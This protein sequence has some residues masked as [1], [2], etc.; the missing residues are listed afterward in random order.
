MLSSVLKLFSTYKYL[1]FA[2]ICAGLA[3]GCGTVAKTLV[4]NNPK[5]EHILT[6]PKA[7]HTVTHEG[8]V[9]YIGEGDSRITVLY[10]SGTPYEMGYE[11]GRLLA[12][13]VKA[14]IADVQVGAYKFLP[15]QLRT[16]KMISTRDEDVI[17]DEFLDRAWEMMARY[18]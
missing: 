11:H 4:M 13:Q 2:S 6:P 10:V 5:V 16:S 9:E 1:A 8:R 18:T 17:I 12:D 15:K 14:T 7:D 3:L